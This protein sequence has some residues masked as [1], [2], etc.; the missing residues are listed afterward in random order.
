MAIELKIFPVY[1]GDSIA[2]LFN[3]SKNCVLIDTGTRRSYIKGGLKVR[4]EKLAKIDLLVLTHTDEDHIGGILKYFSDST[5][6]K[7]IFDK[8]WFNSGLLI[9]KELG[10]KEKEEIEISIDETENLNMSIRQGTTLEKLLLKENIWLQNLIKA[11]DTYNLHGGKLQILSPENEDLATIYEQWELESNHLLNMS[12]SNDYNQPVADLIKN[13]YIENGTIANRSSI[14]FLFE[15][16]NLKILLMGDGFPSVM[17]RNLRKLNW[18]ETNKLKVNIVKVSHHAN[19]HGISPSLLNIIDCNK[20]I[21]ST[22]GSN[23][24]PSKE[25]L[26]RIVAYK[27]EKITLYFNYKND[28]TQNIFSNEEIKN[29]NIEIMY[30]NEDNDYTITIND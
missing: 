6:K 24:L 11:G 8:V 27:S 21:I 25:C 30:L 15:Y 10:L 26:S 9:K 19:K 3:E 16:L 2:I 13:K 12:H 17:E 1:Q 23:G 4:L 5:R 18:S 7:N 28:V 29:Y 20:F 22:D 14:A